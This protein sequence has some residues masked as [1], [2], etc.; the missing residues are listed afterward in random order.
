[1]HEKNGMLTE[2][3]HSD[4]DTSK[5]AA[6]VEKNGHVVADKANKDKL[7]E[8]EDVNP[9]FDGPLGMFGGGKF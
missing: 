5:K 8:P 4:T 6:Y 2:N 7:K 9:M 3:S 1:M